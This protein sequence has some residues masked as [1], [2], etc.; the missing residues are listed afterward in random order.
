[1]KRRRALVLVLALAGLGGLGCVAVVPRSEP[2]PEKVVL[3]HKGKK[4]LTVAAPAADAHRRHGD[5]L[6]PCR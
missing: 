6:G 2:P 3:C 4:T 5:T 1:M